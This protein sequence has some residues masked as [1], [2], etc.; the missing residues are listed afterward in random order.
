M[1]PKFI[2]VKKKKSTIL[3]ECFILSA[4]ILSL[5]DQ[6]LITHKERTEATESVLNN[7]LLSQQFLRSAAIFKGKIQRMR[8]RACR[9]SL[10]CIEITGS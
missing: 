4:K 6:L 3:L 7:A 1:I 8:L 5:E 9:L 10:P 2:V